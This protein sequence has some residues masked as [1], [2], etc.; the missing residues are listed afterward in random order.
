MTHVEATSGAPILRVEGLAKNFPVRAGA[1]LGGSGFVRAVDGVDLTL[2]TGETL[3]LVGESGSGKS[4]TGRMIV[5]LLEPTS[6]RITFLGEDITYLRRRELKRVRAKLQIVFQDPFASLNP[7]LRVKD[8]LAEAL[9]IHGRYERGTSQ[10]WISELLDRVGLESDHAARFP[11]EFSGGQRQRIA[12]ARALTLKPQAIVL[13]EA[14]SALDVSVQA[15]ILNLLEELRDDLG[16]AYLFISH[17][18]SVARHISDR[19]A[20]MYLGRIVEV[21]SSEDVLDRPR[22]PYT[23]ALLSAAPVT[24]PRERGRRVRIKLAGEIPSPTDPP[25]GCVFRTRCWKA[26]ERCAIEIPELEH[27]G[28]PSRQAVA[29]F[30]PEDEGLSS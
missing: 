18:L 26:T 15:Q 6:G 3:A 27:R 29:C 24:N 14:V 21:G 13:D 28:H 9:R 23:R 20:V 7:R 22:H 8:I 11:H 5:R 4:T 2:A 1:H 16:L 25:S 12:I 30:Y 17:D 10:R 19:V